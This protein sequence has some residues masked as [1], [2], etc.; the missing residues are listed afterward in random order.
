MDSVRFTLDMGYQFHDTQFVG[1]ANVVDLILPDKSVS[2]VREK[3]DSAWITLNDAQLRITARKIKIVTNKS[4]RQLFI[5]VLKDE[6]LILD[7][8]TIHSVS[9]AD[10][11]TY[12]RIPFMWKIKAAINHRRELQ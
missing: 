10:Q 6:T 9:A 4:N 8:H 5:T 12:L 11:Y 2:G 7:D 3:L 1:F